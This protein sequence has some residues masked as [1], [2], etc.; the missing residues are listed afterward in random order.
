MT[1]P[2]AKAGL[3]DFTRVIVGQEQG[4]NAGSALNFLP[5][6]NDPTVTILANFGFQDNDPLS[7]TAGV[8]TSSC[9]SINCGTVYW[10]PLGIGAN[11]TGLG[12]QND[13]GTDT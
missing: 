11:P 9:G 8:E 2:S 5:P 10:G 13:L 12:V 7:L 4:G 3:L 6:D 1:G